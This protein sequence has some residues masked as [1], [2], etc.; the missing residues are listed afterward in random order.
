MT[1]TMAIVGLIVLV[2][3]LIWIL[4]VNLKSLI[5]RFHLGIANMFLEEEELKKIQ[6]YYYK[7][8]KSREDRRMYREIHK[9]FISHDYR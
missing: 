1:Q 2:P 8:S 6:R 5:F 3:I 7:A 4:V 9:G